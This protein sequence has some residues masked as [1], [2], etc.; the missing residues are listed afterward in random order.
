M[1]KKTGDEGGAGLWEAGEVGAA[2]GAAPECPGDEFGDAP[3]GEGKG[4]PDARKHHEKREL[5][6]HAAPRSQGAMP[7]GATRNSGCMPGT[8]SRT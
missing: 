2:P 7:P 3:Q 4:R 5:S 1:L 8:C 6:V